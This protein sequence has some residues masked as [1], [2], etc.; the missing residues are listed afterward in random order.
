[1]CRHSDCSDYRGDQL[2]TC[3]FTQG[4]LMSPARWCLSFEVASSPFCVNHL[5]FLQLLKFEE[6]DREWW[7]VLHENI[8]F[9]G[10]RHSFIWYL[11]PWPLLAFGL[12]FDH[13]LFCNNDLF[14]RPNW[15]ICL[16]NIFWHLVKPWEFIKISLTCWLTNKAKKTL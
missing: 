16:V 12:Q 1:M 8:S 4:I 3:V 5:P 7:K 14:Y 11:Y 15:A 13:M 2:L 10:G 9:G 6:S